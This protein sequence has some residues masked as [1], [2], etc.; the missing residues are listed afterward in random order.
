MWVTLVTDKLPEFIINEPKVTLVAKTFEVDIIEPTY[1]DLLIE[2][3]PYVTNDATV[4]LVESEVFKIFIEPDVFDV[5]ILFPFTFNVYPTFDPVSI[6]PLPNNSVFLIL[7]PPRV[8]NVPPEDTFVA[9]AVL[10]ILIPPNNCKDPDVLV[11]RVLS[12]I[13]IPWRNVSISPV[14]IVIL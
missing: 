1:K 11:L 7:I 9:S 2:T 13:S 3:P 8:V 5:K 6:V 10:Y 12:K 4:A 14:D